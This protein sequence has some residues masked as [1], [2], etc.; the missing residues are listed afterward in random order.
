MTRFF[1]LWNALQALWKP[2]PTQPRLAALPSPEIEEIEDFDL[3]P[4]LGWMEEER[5]IQ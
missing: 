4:Y 3:A 5:S 2:M 1:T